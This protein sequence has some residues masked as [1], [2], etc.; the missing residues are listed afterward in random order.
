[1]LD[2]YFRHRRTN[3]GGQRP[4]WEQVH[5]IVLGPCGSAPGTDGFPYEVYQYAPLTQ[6][7]LI[8]QA[9]LY[10]PLGTE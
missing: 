1:M 5:G 9:V 4:T 7:C 2:H 10:A 6:A 3:F 8:A